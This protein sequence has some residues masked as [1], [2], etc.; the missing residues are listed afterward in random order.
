[1]KSFGK[2]KYTTD[3]DKFLNLDIELQMFYSNST[4]DVYKENTFDTNDWYAYKENI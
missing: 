1:M 2:C 3:Y 4:N